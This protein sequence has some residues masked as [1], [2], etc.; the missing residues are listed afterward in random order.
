MTGAFKVTEE[1]QDFYGDLTCAAK[2]NGDGRFAV[3]IS[4]PGWVE[5]SRGL[6]YQAEPVTWPTNASTPM[7]SGYEITAPVLSVIS[8]A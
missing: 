6:I 1:R 5:L 4:F 2:E 3:A 7:Y 8:I